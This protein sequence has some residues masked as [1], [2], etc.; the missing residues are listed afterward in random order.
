MK[1]MHWAGRVMTAIP[2]LFLAF[3]AV[4]KLMQI[5]PVVESFTALGYPASLALGIGTLELV[6]LLVYVTPFTSTLGAILLTGYLGG[7]VATHVRMGDPL[8]SH[9]LFPV[10]VGVLIWGG[11]FLRD[12][13]LRALIPVRKTS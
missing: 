6:C 7:G 8:L 12:E 4:I 11:L 1:K 3:D 10:Y 9:S 5:T 2:V 13:R